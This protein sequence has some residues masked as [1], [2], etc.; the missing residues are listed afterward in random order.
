MQVPRLERASLRDAVIRTIEDALLAGE[1]RPGDRLIESDLAQRAGISRGPVREAVRQLV[2][3]G[4]LVSYPSRGTFVTLWSPRAVEEA[5]S[6]RAVLERLAIREAAQRITDDQVAQLAATVDEMERCARQGDTRQLV[7]LD[8][9]FHEQLYAFC[10]HTLLQ[11]TLSQLR[12]Q[13]YSLMGM[14]E[15]FAL[16]R[17][18]I[19]TDHRLI[20]DSLR[21]R[22]PEAAGEAIAAHILASGAE[23][24]AQVRRLAS[25]EPG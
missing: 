20:V 4:V 12:R 13:L 19:A 17:D 21:G 25:D 5:Y 7:R 23:V 9:R 8:V 1:L 15:G 10:G 6:L 18:E 16:H 11:R 2:G 22:D 3:E 14:D 24:V